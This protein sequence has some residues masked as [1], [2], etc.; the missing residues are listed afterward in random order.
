VKFNKVLLIRYPEDPTDFRLSS[1]KSFYDKL[2]RERTQMWTSILTLQEVVW[3]VLW[4]KII[5]QIKTLGFSKLTYGEFKR[6]YPSEYKKTFKE[7]RPD[8]KHTFDTFFAFDIQLRVP[9]TFLYQK[10]KRIAQY[11]RAILS[12]YDLEPADAFHI[13]T[14]KV[15]K[16]NFIVSNDRG[17]QDVDTISIYAYSKKY[18]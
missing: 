2:L 3:K 8:I 17:F 9:T 5:G 16:T 1:C 10:G 12:R 18:N 13:A 7:I 6:K 15:G 11:A 14:A 4:G